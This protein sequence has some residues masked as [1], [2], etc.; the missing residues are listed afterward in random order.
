MHAVTAVPAVMPK[1]DGKEEER[2]STQWQNENEMQI[3]STLQ[4]PVFLQ[5]G[6]SIPEL[7]MSINLQS[8]HLRRTRQA[9]PVTTP[10]KIN[11]TVAS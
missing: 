6:Q 7:N 11:Y 4:Y 1:P 10:C 8:K 2:Q 9:I 5:P 3:A